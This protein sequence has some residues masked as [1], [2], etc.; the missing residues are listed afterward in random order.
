MHQLI[1]NHEPCGMRSIPVFAREINSQEL[2][3]S[4]LTRLPTYRQPS[5][6]LINLDRRNVGRKKNQQTL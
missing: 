2:Q 4:H 3:F 5:E 6:C 1:L